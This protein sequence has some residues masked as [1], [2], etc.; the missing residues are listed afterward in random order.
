MT[1]QNI[2][3]EMYQWAVELYPICRSITGPGVRETLAYIK[4]IIPALEIHEV[5]SGTQ[6]FDW[7]VPDEWAVRDA[8]IAD[9]AGKRIVDFKQHNLHLGNR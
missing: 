4:K 5:T 1:N 6:A 3:D 7:V 2:G 9:E 8:Y